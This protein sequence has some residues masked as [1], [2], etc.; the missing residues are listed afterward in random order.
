[1]H[2]YQSVSAK[3]S[4]SFKVNKA[5]DCNWILDVFFVDLEKPTKNYL[6]ALRNHLLIKKIEGCFDSSDSFF[7]EDKIDLILQIL[8]VLSQTRYLQFQNSIHKSSSNLDIC[9]SNDKISRTDIF[10]QKLQIYS[11][12]FDLLV[13]QL[14][15][16]L[17]FYNQNKLFQIEIEK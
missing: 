17:D 3:V 4:S 16:M 1:M 7:S 9:L 15:I 2:L 5:L 13:L 11:W 6:L 8:I 12:T 14:A 10:H